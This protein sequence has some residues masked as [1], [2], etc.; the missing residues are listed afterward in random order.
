MSTDLGSCA[1]CISIRFEDVNA[2][3]PDGLCW[4]VADAVT[5]V[6][7]TSACALHAYAAVKVVGL[8]ADQ[9][10]AASLAGIRW[11]R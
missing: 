5:T 10:R 6:V 7:G 8:L 11:P 1:M 9:W 3:R 4:Q 2:H